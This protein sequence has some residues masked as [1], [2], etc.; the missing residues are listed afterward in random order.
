MYRVKE[1]WFRR[2]WKWLI[3]VGGIVIFGFIT[4]FI[5]LI[6]TLIFGAIKSSDVYQG[7]LTKVKANPEI[8]RELGEPIEPGWL[9]EGSIN[10]NNDS[11]DANLEIPISGP[12]KAATVY[13]IA[14]KEKGKWNYSSLEVAVDGENKRIDLLS[15]GEG[16]GD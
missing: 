11:G 12:R 13:V 1:S 8:V 10:I 14:K 3:P 9:V 5:V 16:R 4:A 15:S 2:N 6:L 7:A